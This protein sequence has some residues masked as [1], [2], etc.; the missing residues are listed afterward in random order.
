MM[1]L[2]LLYTLA[3]R[4]YSVV[5][6]AVSPFNTKA[7]LWVEGRKNW[8]EKITKTPADACSIW[9]H[10]SSL[11]EFEQ[12]RP[13]IEAIK[14]AYP[15]ARLT[16]TF[17]SPSGYTL[18]HNYP[19]ADQVLYLPADT[20]RNAQDFLNAIRPDLAI[21]VKYDFWANYLITLHERQIPTILVSALFR[22]EQA[23]FQWHGAFWRRVLQAFSHIFVQEA[24]SAKLLQEIDFQN[25]SIAGDTRVDRVMRI[26]A[27]NK[28]N[29]VVN[30]FVRAKNAP[31]L[32]AG[33]TWPDDERTLADAQKHS[34][35]WPWRLII[36]PHEPS[37]SAIQHIEQ[38]WPDAV[39]YSQFTPQKSQSN[40]LIIDNVGMLNTLYRYAT[41]AMIGGGFGKGIHNT[42][43]PAAFGLPIIFGPRFYKFEEARQLTARQGAF[44]V[45]NASDLAQTLQTLLEVNAYDKAAQAVQMYMQENQGATQQIMDWIANNIT[46]LRDGDYN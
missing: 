10:V 38:L 22:P 42:L 1:L 32:V 16:L 15:K 23:F 24:N 28:S 11:G 7:K 20:P 37:D 25:I 27:E 44:S 2:R 36:A 31:V 12:G 14:S 43:E 41:V 34:Q 45:Q 5:I 30:D 29:D 9:M 8:R 21:F 3:I 26:A 35:H 40:V 33:S 18:R 46:C 6:H 13:L 17:F 39:R 19:L 4:L